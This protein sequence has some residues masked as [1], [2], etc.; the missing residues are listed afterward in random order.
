MSIRSKTVLDIFFAPSMLFRSS[1]V[2]IGVLEPVLAAVAVLLPPPPPH[3]DN[4][5]ALKKVT[6]ANGLMMVLGIDV[7]IGVDLF[8][9]TTIGTSSPNCG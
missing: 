7:I 2:V 3:P 1:V 6:K 4:K 5:A 8:G 9:S